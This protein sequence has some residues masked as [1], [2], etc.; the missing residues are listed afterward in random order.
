MNRHEETEY[1]NK[2]NAYNLIGLFLFLCWRP[3]YHKTYAWERRKYIS[4]GYV[5]EG[6]RS[7]ERPRRNWDDYI[8]IDIKE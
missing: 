2:T 7:L 4:V 3:E 6:K 8:D 5:P 1:L